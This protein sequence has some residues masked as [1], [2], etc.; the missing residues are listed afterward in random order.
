[1]MLLVLHMISV[2]LRRCVLAD[3]KNRPRRGDTG[4]VAM[5]SVCSNLL[6]SPT[7]E[8]MQRDRIR[9]TEWGAWGR[10]DAGT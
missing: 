5:P 2:A 10:E 7:W 1:M 8:A 4:A 6:P 9:D 3:G